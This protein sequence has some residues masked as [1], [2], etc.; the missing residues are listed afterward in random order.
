MPPRTRSECGLI[1][2][3]NDQNGVH[4]LAC[5]LTGL[6]VLNY[7]T[8]SLLFYTWRMLYPPS[9]RTLSLPFPSLAFSSLLS[10]IGG[11]GL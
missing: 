7:I 9:L 2:C 5:L 1:G 4:C 6:F 10:L 8:F 11:H 3:C